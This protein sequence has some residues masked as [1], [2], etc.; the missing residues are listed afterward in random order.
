MVGKRKICIYFLSTLIILLNYSL[1]FTEIIFQDNFNNSPDWQSNQT[2]KKSQPGGYDISWKNTRQDTCTSLCPPKGWTSYRTA[3]SIWTDNRRKDTFLLNAEGARGGS[4]KGIVYNVEVSGTFGIWTGG[5]LD[6]WLGK[7]GY[8]EL[9]IRYY[10]KFDPLWK[11]TNASSTQ[12]HLQKIIRINTFNDNIWTSTTN[13]QQFGKS[14]GKNMPVWL[15]E[16]YYNKFY[17]PIHLSSQVRTAP[18]YTP[19]ASI[20]DYNALIPTDGQWHCYEFHVKMNTSPG[21]PD[22]VWGFYIDGK[23]KSEK[24]DIAWK[25]KDSNLK[26]DWNWLMLLDNV[27]N[28]SATKEDHIEMQMY[29][30]DVIVSTTYIGPDSSFLLAKPTY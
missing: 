27:T 5:S 7:V 15:V 19:L 29:M 24:K 30:D 8:K 21:V 23:L 2:I 4:G 10:L 6:I 13:P 28:I 18:D 14:Q 11:W 17:P 1:A 25:A 9:Y 20:E 16:L 3:S 26:H 22:G 12:H